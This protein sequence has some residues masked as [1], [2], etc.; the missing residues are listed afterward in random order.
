M[1]QH[2]RNGVGQVESVKHLRITLSADQH[3]AFRVLAAHAGESM[4]KH[5][6]R[7]IGDYIRREAPP[8]R[9]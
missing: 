6:V 3:R 7:V 1:P 9:A 2:K 8:R 5:A 4:F